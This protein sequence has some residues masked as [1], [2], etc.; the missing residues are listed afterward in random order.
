MKG[1]LS[2]YYFSFLLLRLFLEPSSSHR[3]QLNADFI[4]D[5]RMAAQIVS[6]MS[7][8]EIINTLGHEVADAVTAHSDLESFNLVRAPWRQVRKFVFFPGFLDDYTVMVSELFTSGAYKAMPPEE[9]LERVAILTCLRIFNCPVD[10]L[11]G[12]LQNIYNELLYLRI[13]VR[14]IPVSSVVGDGTSSSSSSS[15]KPED[16]VINQVDMFTRPWH[17]L[18]QSIRLFLE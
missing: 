16:R 14:G 15:L 8:E 6:R 5:H 1:D 2:M 11:P 9:C 7:E 10:D 4:R 18:L 17:P 3:G 12:L 13:S